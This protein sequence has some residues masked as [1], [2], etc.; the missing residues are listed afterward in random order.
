[1][2][3]CA[4]LPASVRRR[5]V[6]NQAERLRERVSHDAAADDRSMVGFWIWG[7]RNVAVALG[8]LATAAGL[9]GVLDWSLAMATVLVFGV[10]AASANHL[11][12][13]AAVRRARRRAAIVG[14]HTHEAL[15]ERYR[16]RAA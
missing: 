10:I 13:H 8:G 1:M 5:P 7:V 2:R 6:R 14:L 12:R 9:S 4:E 11:A 15:L 3:A 16:E